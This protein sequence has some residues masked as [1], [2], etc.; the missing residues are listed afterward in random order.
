MGRWEDVIA[1]TPEVREPVPDDLVPFVESRP[2]QWTCDPFGFEP[3]PEEQP[4]AGGDADRPD[5]PAVTATI[6]HGE[7]YLD[8]GYLRNPPEL[9]LS[10][11][12]SIV[13][14]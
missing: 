6:W 13:V 12:G 11:W 8:L 14:C 7:R 10:T 2:A 1:L 9:R 3:E 4:N 5:H